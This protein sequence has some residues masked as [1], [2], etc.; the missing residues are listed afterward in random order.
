MLDISFIDDATL[1]TI[2]ATCAGGDDNEGPCNVCVFCPLYASLFAVLAAHP[3]DD[4]APTIDDA[5]ASPRTS[6]KPPGVALC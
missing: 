3:I 4:A 5:A 6:F 1:R 2:A